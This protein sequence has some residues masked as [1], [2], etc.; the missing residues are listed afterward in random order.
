MEKSPSAWRLSTPETS[1]CCEWSGRRGIFAIINWTD[2]QY[3]DVKDLPGY[4][5]R[6]DAQQVHKAIEEYASGILGIWYATDEDV[7]EDN[8]LQAWSREICDPHLGQVRAFPEHLTSR[9]QL[10]KIATDVIF[11]CSAQHAAVNNG[12]FGA[13]GWVP[14]A[15]VAV[16]RELPDNLPEDGSALYSQKDFYRALPN[17]ARTF[18]QTGMVWLLSE[19]TQHSLFRSGAIPAFSQENCFEAHRVVGRFR[20]RLRAVSDAIDVRNTEIGFEYNFLKPQNIDQSVS[21]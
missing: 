5:Y 1:T 7:R 13:Y 12:Q 2:L 16:Y 18:G 3:R 21:I 4:L 11:R 8:E 15:P 20:H 19:P 17:R 9:E 10:F 14:N 6:D